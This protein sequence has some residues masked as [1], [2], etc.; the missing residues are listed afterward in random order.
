M[1]PTSASVKYLMGPEEDHQWGRSEGTEVG[2]SRTYL[3][4]IKWS[5][6]N[7]PQISYSPNSHSG[8][9]CHTCVKTRDMWPAG[10]T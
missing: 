1:E 9:V 8:M 2:A 4:S 10:L 3:G 5:E 7:Q 6:V